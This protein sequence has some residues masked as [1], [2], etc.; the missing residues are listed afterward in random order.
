MK[1]LLL[2]TNFNFHNKTMSM[3]ICPYNSIILQINKLYNYRTIII[4]Q[5]HKFVKPTNCQI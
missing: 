4:S 2:K 1:Y 5:M 3:P